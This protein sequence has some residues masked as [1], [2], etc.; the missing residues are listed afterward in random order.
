MTVIKQYKSDWGNLIGFFVML[1]IGSIHPAK[2][3]MMINQE[4]ISLRLYTVS[5]GGT[6]LQHTNKKDRSVNII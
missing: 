3:L 5:E 2:T 4:I 1:T 6:L